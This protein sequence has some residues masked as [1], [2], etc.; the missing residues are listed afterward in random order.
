MGRKTAQRDHVVISRQGASA[1]AHTADLAAA[2]LDS[3]NAGAVA[4]LDTQCLCHLGQAV[5]E[6]KAIA[7]LIAGQAQSAHKLLLGQLQCR[8]DLDKA[9]A[10]QHLKRYLVVLKHFHVFGY[11][12]QLR[13]GA[14]QL[15]RA[16][17]AV[18]V[19]NAGLGAQLFQAIAAVLGN[20][21]HAALVDGISLLGAIC[22]HG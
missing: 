9:G 4:K 1:G 2:D 11:A 14:K 10:V 21:H 19:A 7:G 8:L 17:G 3:V 22:Q 6:F 5:G 20:R 15:Q 18:V 16:L 13:L 12:I